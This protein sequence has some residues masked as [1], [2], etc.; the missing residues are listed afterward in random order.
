MPFK[1]HVVFINPP[2]LSCRR[3]HLRY[4]QTNC[5]KIILLKALDLPVHQQSVRGREVVRDASSNSHCFKPRATMNFLLRKGEVAQISQCFKAY[6]KW[7]EFS[8]IILYII[9]SR[10]TDD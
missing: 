5:T 7:S 6:V 2:L 10:Q 8:Y 1:P 9:L 3:I 4:R